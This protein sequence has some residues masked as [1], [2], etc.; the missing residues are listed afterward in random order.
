MK[1]TTVILFV[2]TPVVIFMLLVCTA[3]AAASVPVIYDTDMCL[4]VDDVGALAVLHGLQNEEKVNLLGGVCCNEVHPLGASVIDAINTYSLHEEITNGY[5]ISYK[6]IQ[7]QNEK[8]VTIWIEAENGLINSPMK[9]WDDNKASAGSYIEVESGNGS[10]K[11]APAN[12]HAIYKFSVSETGLYKIW[13]R[14]IASMDDEDAFWIKLDNN[15]WIMWRD[16]SISCR[17][18]WDEV[19]DNSLNNSPVIFNLEKGVHTL[20]VA[21]LLD[22]TRLDKILITNDMDFVPSTGGPGVVARFSSNPEKSILK[23]DIVFDAIESY[24]TEGKIIRYNWNFSDGHKSDEKI[25]KYAF[26]KP[27]IY[28]TELIVEDELGYTGKSKQTIEVFADEPV[29]QLKAT[30]DHIKSGMEVIFDASCSFHPDGAIKSYQWDFGDGKQGDGRIVTHKFYN[31]GKYTTILSVTD[32]SGNVKTQQKLITVISDN[33]KKVIFE[34]DMCLDVD[35]AGALAMLHAL[36]DNGEAEI[37]AVCFN[38]VHSFGA[39]AIDAINTWYGRGDIPIGIFKGEFEDPDFSPYLEHVSG[40]PNDIKTSE[41]PDAIDVYKRILKNQADKSV[42]IISVGFLNNISKLLREEP[43]LVA[44]KVNNLIVMGG[45]NNDG[46]NFSRHNLKK[47]TEYVFA[48]WPTPIVISQPG[49]NILTG[50]PLM[51][52]PIG[53]PVREAYFKF[54]HNSFCNRPS[55][56]QVAVLYAIRGLHDYFEMKEIGSGR[57]SN[58]YTFSMKPDWRT[59]ITIKLS[60]SYYEDLINQLMMQLPKNN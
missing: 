11:I 21:Y 42:T 17:W 31:E 9:I 32:E 44:E 2:L 56:D 53:N 37:L 25:F 59:Y 8:G 14:V 1:L 10:E 4:D 13:G 35:D 60:N 58:G 52:T 15:D 30:P 24:S 38:E 54:F 23:K 49:S 43:E 26:E 40:F 41:V 36:A 46:F 51:D 5:E 47:E 28:H 27:G 18:H 39:S 33:P 20:T 16:I 50:I 45:V 48:N 34:T 6:T 19:H 7:K 22:Q 55:W 57:L 29:V 3:K 12:G